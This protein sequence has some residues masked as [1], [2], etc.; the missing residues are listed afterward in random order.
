MRCTFRCCQ[1]S[2]QT[3]ESHICT[4]LYER[5]PGSHTKCLNLK[6]HLSVRVT[7]SIGV[8][9]NAVAPNMMC[10]ALTWFHAPTALRQIDKS[11]HMVTG[12]APSHALQ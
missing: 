10:T 1:A 4:A 6:W 8:P 2:W 5:W 9:C 3:E 7:D 11:C 12:V